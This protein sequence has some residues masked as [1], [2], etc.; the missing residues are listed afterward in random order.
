MTSYFVILEDPRVFR[1][2]SILHTGQSQSW[3]YM[4][5][6]ALSHCIGVDTIDRVGRYLSNSLRILIKFH[7]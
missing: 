3:N 1:Y 2:E 5:M 6:F 7:L 4:Y